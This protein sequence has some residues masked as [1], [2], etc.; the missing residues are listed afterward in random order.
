MATPKHYIYASNNT[1]L[2]YTINDVVR[3]DPIVPLTVSKV[4]EITNFRANGAIIINGGYEP[5]DLTI[6]ARL[7]G[8]NYAALLS[9][10]DSLKSTVL[11]NVNYYLKYDKTMTNGESLESIKVRLKS[12][13]ID[14]ARGNM[15]KFCYVILTFR[16]LAWQ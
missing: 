4:V 7:A 2:V 5:Y 16:A 12:I 11:P 1:S 8:A 15:N 9:A 14:S 13:E 6:E 3:R 10:I